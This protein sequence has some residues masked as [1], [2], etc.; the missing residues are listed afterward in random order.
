MSAYPSAC[1]SE[2]CGRILCDGCS[3]RPNLKA[4]Y[5]SLGTG[6]AYEQRQAVLRQHKV[7]RTGPFDHLKPTTD[8]QP[9]DA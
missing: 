8:P 1:Y 4:H 7:D 3:N 9:G 5:E 6:E 2:F